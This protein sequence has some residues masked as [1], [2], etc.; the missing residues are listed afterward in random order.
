MMP[1]AE[2]YPWRRGHKYMLSL[3]RPSSPESSEGWGVVTGPPTKKL[4]NAL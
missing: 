2:S 1:R 4:E 3:L